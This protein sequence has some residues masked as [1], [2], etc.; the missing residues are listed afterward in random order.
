[1]GCCMNCMHNL[2]GKC[3]PPAPVSFVYMRAPV[4][5]YLSF[6]PVYDETGR[7]R[8]L[9]SK[10]PVFDVQLDWRCKHHQYVPVLSQ[11]LET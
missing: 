5:S 10:T 9:L 6:G 3:H 11:V 4:S 2:G 1:M 7:L 8:C